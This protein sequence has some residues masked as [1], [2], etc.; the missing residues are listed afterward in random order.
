M[1]RNK[2][3]VTW[4]I[5][6]IQILVFLMME[7]VGSTQDVNLLV[8]FGAKYNPFIAAG[9]Y[10]RLITPMFIHIG[11]AHLLFNSLTLYYL[12]TMVEQLAGHLKFLV[13]YLLAGVMGN[14]F[15]YQFSDSI[16][17]GA[18]TSLFG[19]FAFFIALANI[20]PE[21]RGIQQLSDQYRG[22]I[23]INIVLNLFMS[24][25]DIAGHIGGAVGGFLI[26]YA[27][28]SN[29]NTDNR[30]QRIAA[31]IIYFAMAAIIVVLR[32]YTLRRGL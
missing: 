17:A 30:S 25:V 26:S 4:I 10:W 5:L 21:S 8:L 1:Q 7:L 14:L 3:F 22:L 16:S 2:P 19:L 18:S 29:R 6:A 11:F 31:G 12:G 28:M 9:Q 32:G 13:I 27:L 20:Y 15:S 24:N 23:L